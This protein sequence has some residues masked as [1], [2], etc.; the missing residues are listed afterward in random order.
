[1][2]EYLIGQTELNKNCTPI[3]KDAQAFVHDSMKIVGQLI[4]RKIS[5][6]SKLKV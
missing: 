6:N 5:R 1:M 2:T 3:I 4:L